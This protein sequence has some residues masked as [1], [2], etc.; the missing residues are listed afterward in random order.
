MLS[1]RARITDARLLAFMTS[2]FFLSFAAMLWHGPWSLPVLS[3]GIALL[4]M[5]VRAHHFSWRRIGLIFVWQIGLVLLLYM[6]RFGASGLIDG[7]TVGYRL[8]LVILPGA[9]L[10][11]ALPHGDMARLLV[12]FLPTRAG[13]VIT[14]CVFFFPTLWSVTVQTYESQVLR[15]ARI[16]PRELL[17]PMNWP[18]VVHGICLPAI[19][20]SLALSRD[21]A[22]AAHCRWYG[23]HP[24]RTTWPGPPPLNHPGDPHA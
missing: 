20:T 3:L 14:T 10:M 22:L 8:V 4:G 16:L 12:R 13:F 24:D 7:L 5:S 21:I 6:V 1:A 18:L 17:N 9:L 11:K 23:L 15:G 2:A 19:M